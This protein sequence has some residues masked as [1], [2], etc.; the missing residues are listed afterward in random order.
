MLVYILRIKGT[1]TILGLYTTVEK[2][3][4]AWKQYYENIQ[5]EHSSLDYE[6]MRNST[7]MKEE[8]LSIKLDGI[9]SPLFT[10]K[11]HIQTK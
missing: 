11:I 9:P 2:A 10:H 1:S 7:N 6:L 4:L 3:R 8:I 5:T